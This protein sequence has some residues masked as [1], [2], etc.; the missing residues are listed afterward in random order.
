MNAHRF[1]NRW[2]LTWKIPFSY[3][4]HQKSGEEF[5]VPY[6]S[7]RDY[8]RFL[9]EK[10][11]EL[12]YGGH[13]AETGGNHLA[14]FW[15]N[16]ELVHPTHAMFTEA[17]N[18]SERKP[19]NTFCLAFHGDE[20]RGL[21]RGNTAVI[22]FETV[23][24]LMDPLNPKDFSRCDTCCL[25]RPMA[26]RFN[27]EHGCLECKKRSDEI[28]LAAQQVSNY[29]QH[30]FLTKWVLAVLPHA[31]Y[32]QTDLL[33]R[34][35]AITVKDF[36]ALFE[37][38]IVVES[39]KYFACLVGLKGDL[40][41]HQEIC[42]LKR[43]FNKQ[44][45]VNE[46]MCHQCLAGTFDLPWEDTNV[47]PCWEA[48][49]FTVRPW[50]QTSPPSIV[51]LPFDCETPEK[52][53]RRD[54][55]HNVKLGTFRDFIAG[56]VLLLCRLG[57]FNLEGESSDRPTLLER[58]HSHFRLWCVARGKSPS[59]R[60]FTTLLFNITTWHDYGWINAKG[61]D[62]TLCI[63]WLRTLSK[64]LLFDLR[65]PEHKDVIETIYGASVEGERMF[66]LLYGHGIWLNRHCAATLFESIHAFQLSY[67]KLSFLALYKY[68]YTA[69][70]KK[71]K[72]H[73][74]S[75]EK[76]DLRC[77]LDN[78][79]VRYILSPLVFACEG[80]E[81]MIGKLCRLSRRVSQRL[82]AQRT[83]ELYLI[84]CKTIHKR[85]QNTQKRKVKK[86]KLKSV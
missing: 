84:Q 44:L 65:D 54:M 11:P 53:L 18:S 48:S 73:M 66:K 28:P 14:K 31:Y 42:A 27:C 39:K 1:V 29:K 2:G 3:I 63:S 13:D 47:E 75:H 50:D 77:C 41:W 43:C 85:F 15:E 34:I 80:N 25:G 70:A 76:I 51:G 81:D 57:Y 10:A 8:V 59:L 20:G 62:V 36:R 4:A 52:I 21:K 7:V 78:T 49:V 6:I 86:S 67:N 79:N 46:P 22:M 30:S 32:K 16:Y 9:V 55:F 60:S 38:G 56:S 23:L 64:G 69:F 17:G 61:S 12:L 40:R 72:F 24:G 5:D 68:F 71:S 19:N 33:D 74:M 82:P 58:A 35:I 26:K 83:L 37:E 45:K